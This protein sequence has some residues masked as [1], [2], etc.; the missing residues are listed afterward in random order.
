MKAIKVVTAISLIISMLAMPVLAAEFVP[1]IE[2]KDGPQIVDVVLEYDTPCRTLHIIPY[3]HIHLDDIIDEEELDIVYEISEEMEEE[4]RVSQRNAM[5]ELKNNPID[6]LV[7]GFREAWAEVTGGAPLE[8]AVVHDLFEMVLICSEDDAFKYDE[9]VTVSFT[10]DGIGADD[11]FV[12][13]YKPTGSDEWI[14]GEYEIDE[15]GVI[16]MT[17]DKLCPFAIIKDSGEAPAISSDAPQS[18][19]TGVYEAWTA[20][21]FVGVA[22]LSCVAVVLSKKLRKTTVQ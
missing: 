9:K 22:A 15:N 14:V 16:T 18:P 10:V 7:T 3:K 6:E 12:I 4:I 21:A 17:I 19:Q 20:A 5:E 11:L 13:V 2:L 1:S 8:N